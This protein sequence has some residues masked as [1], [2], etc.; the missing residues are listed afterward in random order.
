[1]VNE[2]GYSPFGYIISLVCGSVFLLA[3][4]LKAGDLSVLYSTLLYD[5]V[6]INFL[7]PAKHFGSGGCADCGFVVVCVL[8]LAGSF[9]L[10]GWFW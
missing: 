8:S 7:L 1:M 2:R 6:P 5:S 3:R 9:F 4:L 10:P